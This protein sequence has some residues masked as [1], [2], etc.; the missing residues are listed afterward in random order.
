M[1]VIDKTEIVALRQSRHVIDIL[2]DEASNCHPFQRP[3]ELHLSTYLKLD[4]P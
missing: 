3:L 1:Y 4:G 2:A